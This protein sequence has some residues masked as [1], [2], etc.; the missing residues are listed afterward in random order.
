MQ[1]NEEKH[2]KRINTFM[3]DR[4]RLLGSLVDTD[5]LK[6]ERFKKVLHYNLLENIGLIERAGRYF[7]E[8]KKNGFK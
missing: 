8:E 2:I 6:Q 4:L 3:K 5:R 7:D 1:S